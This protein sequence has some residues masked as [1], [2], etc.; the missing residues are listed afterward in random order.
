MLIR[1]F[2][3]DPLDVKLVAS[4][5]QLKSEIDAG[6][7]KSDWTVDELLKYYRDNGIVI[8][9]SDLYTLVQNDP[10]KKFIHNIQGDNVIFKGYQPAEDLPAD[11]NKK[12]VKQMAKSALK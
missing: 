1:E 7:E 11:D 9:K 2:D 4:T 3:A 10:L 5:S 6:H 12:I 8:G